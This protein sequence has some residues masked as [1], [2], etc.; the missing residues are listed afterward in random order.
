[1]NL[2]TVYDATRSNAGQLPK[3]VKAAGY[4]TGTGTVPWYAADWQAHPD[5]VRICQDVGATDTTADVLDVERGAATVADVVPWQRAA[6]KNRSEGVRPGQRW[7]AIYV[8][9][10]G[11]T[12]VA[13]AL[14]A[15][16][17]T[18]GVFLWIANWNLTAQ[19]ADTDVLT[20]SGPWPIVAVQYKS[21]ASYDLSVVSGAWWGNVTPTPAVPSHPTKTE[22]AAAL[23]T[24]TAYVAAH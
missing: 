14:Q 24:L 11:L 19:Q 18:S 4:T 2:I 3:G 8:S 21:T 13:N 10:A 16:K 1:M 20:G 5:A 12:P 23:V 17:I 9:A 6:W 22:A 7:P 15:A